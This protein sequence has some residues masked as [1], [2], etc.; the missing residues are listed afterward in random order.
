MF[1]RKDENV[2]R[3]SRHPNWAAFHRACGAAGLFFD[4]IDPVDDN[5]KDVTNLPRKG[6]RAVTFRIERR[7]YGVDV[8]HVVS[9][10]R[11]PDPIA[12]VIDAY[13]QALDA[14]Y[15]VPADLDAM[16]DTVEPLPVPD[17][18]GLIG[19]QEV[20]DIAGLIG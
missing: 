10:G 19:P 1:W 4:D 15:P 7:S 12:A 20:D 17:L 11:G 14:G 18:S 8:S 2:A 9:R 3:A 13:R 6:Y 16:F 5:L